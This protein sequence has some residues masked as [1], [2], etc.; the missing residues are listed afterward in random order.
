[1][2][3]TKSK[4]GESFTVLVLFL[5]T[6]ALT[7]VF[8]KGYSPE[9]YAQGSPAMQA[10]WASI[11]VVALVRALPL[12]HRI[13][14][15]MQSNPTLLALMLLALVSFSWSIEPMLT[16]RRAIALLFTTVFAVDFGVRYSVEKQLQL[17]TVTI[18]TALFVSA[19]VS[20]V[21][22]GLV[23][24]APWPTDS[25]SGNGWNGLFPHKNAFGQMLAY[26]VLVTI[27]NYR[28]G[29]APTIMAAL[30]ICA[31]FGLILASHSGTSL[32]LSVLMLVLWPLLNILRWKRRTARTLGVA[33]VLVAV[34]AAGFCFANVDRLA[35]QIDRKTDLTGRTDVWR[36][37]LERASERPWVGY[38]YNGFWGTNEAARISDLVGWPVPN[39]HNG[40]LDVFIQLGALGALAFLVFTMAGLI[41]SIHFASGWHGGNPLWPLASL[42]LILSNSLTESYL[43]SANSFAW[44]IFIA[45]LST[46]S[47]RISH[48]QVPSVP[49]IPAVMTD[50]NS[51]Y[52]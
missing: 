49:I 27:A 11:Y 18:G 36:L 12:R 45:A 8:L 52:A 30:C 43:L 16:L 32:V 37:T 40:F 34:L 38:G 1:M 29:A 13:L 6:S 15:V 44:I 10:C 17:I 28:R 31:L 25:S 2:T 46:V 20:L 7:T 41:R 50:D 26:G 35:S 39:G 5:S 4:L 24:P 47:I 14:R 51:A 9:A 33:A 22:P 21:A 23:P 3:I 42:L 19:L 48:S